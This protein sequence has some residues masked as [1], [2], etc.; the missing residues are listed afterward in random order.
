MLVL[1][2]TGIVA[3]RLVPGVGP[4]TLISAEGAEVTALGQ[5]SLVLSLG[6]I[7]DP[8]R[9]QLPSGELLSRPVR[10]QFSTDLSAEAGLWRRRIAFSLG[11]PVVWWQAGDRLQN[12]G[13]DEAPL[14]TTRAGDLR[15][16]LKAT[17]RGSGRVHL[18]VLVQVTVP[19]GGQS[20]FVATDGVT[21]EPRL[22]L[23]AHLGR[24]FLAVAAGVR[25]APERDLFQTRLGDELTWSLGVGVVAWQRRWIHLA[26]LSEAAGAVG[27]S[28]GSRPAEVRGAL[29]L[30]L[31]PFT[32]DAGAGAGLDGE[33]AA[34][35]WRAFVLLR[36]LVGRAR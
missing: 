13:V 32:V 35:S 10:W 12:T 11:L 31:G 16:R 9:L 3:D 22:I 7:R 14:G 33:V 24:V 20:D 28:P 6:L 1:A 19:L 26:A 23:D 30:G 15:L 21:V 34:P 36:A 5:G 25:F 2:S 4:V 18:A 27:G 29:R 17:V 8:L